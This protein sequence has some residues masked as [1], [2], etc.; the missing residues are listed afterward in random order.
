MREGACLQ[1]MHDWL[2]QFLFRRHRQEPAPAWMIF[3]VIYAF[4]FLSHLPLLRLPYFWDEAGYYIPAAYDFFRTGALVPY[5]TLTNAHPPLPAMYLA[6]WWK[7]GGFVPS[8]TRIAICMVA[9]LAL[10]AVFVLVRRLMNTPVAVATTLLTAL[11]PVWF[12]QST[13]AQADIFAAAGTMWALAYALEELPSMRRGWWATL[14]FSLAVLS[15][16]TAVVT[17]LALVGWHIWET[18]RKPAQA[19]GH[20]RAAVQFTLPVVPLLAWYSYHFHKT[21]YIFGNPQFVRYNAVLTLHVL[22]FILALGQRLM[23]ITV[24]MNLFVPVLC[25]V[26]AM[27]LPALRQPD[28]TRRPRVSW[29]AQAQIGIILLANVLFFSVMGGALLARYLL[30][31][32]PL[33]LLLC[34]STWRRRLLQ[35]RWMVALSGVAFI[36]GLFVNPPYRFAPEDNLTYRSM[37]VMQQ[38]AIAQ[39]LHRAPG[40]TVLTAWPATD[41]LTRP[42]LGYVRQPVTVVAIDNFS[43]PQIQAATQLPSYDAALVFSTKYESDITP[44]WL[45]FGDGDWNRRYFGYHNDLPPALI[46]QLL[47]GELVWRIRSRGLWT[48]VILF[49]RPQMADLF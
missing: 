18:R 35:W 38:Q 4:V 15:K 26:A 32:Y 6:Y 2:N 42:E 12:T 44:S 34:V 45:R 24:Y 25:M 28:G 41:E 23:Q 14:W 30:P 40:G 29:N 13:L 27:F 7:L 16:E 21:G 1:A 43:L 22:R 3:P 19:A 9:T 49:N 47:H 20:W 37:I 33:I 39:I 10:T 31:L 48:A 5:S 17:P 11:Y 8:V 46:A 36:A